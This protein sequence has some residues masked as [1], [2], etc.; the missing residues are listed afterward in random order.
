MLPTAPDLKAAELGAIRKLNVLIGT[1]VNKVTIQKKVVSDFSKGM[2]VTPDIRDG[3]ALA[4][5]SA[6]TDIISATEFQVGF[7]SGWV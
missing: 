2:R 7:G 1:E 6:V 4:M 3:Q 5:S